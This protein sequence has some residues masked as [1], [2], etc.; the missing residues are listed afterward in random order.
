MARED[1]Q[2]A[3]LLAGTTDEEVQAVTSALQAARLEAR[4]EGWSAAVAALR[5]RAVRLWQLNQPV[6]AKDMRAAA[7]YLE[8]LATPSL[9]PAPP[10][11]GGSE[12]GRADG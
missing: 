8:S 4:T 5:G 3:A 1:Y 12:E 2:A 11:A 10:N 9:L 7:D 6:A